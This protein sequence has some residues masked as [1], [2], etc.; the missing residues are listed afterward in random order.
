MALVGPIPAVRCLP[1]DGRRFLP[2]YRRTSA[3]RLG[4]KCTAEPLA[5][6]VE[7]EA[8]GRVK[9]VM[10]FSISDFAVANQVSVGLH[11]RVSASTNCLVIF[12]DCT[13]L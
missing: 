1:S 9:S 6:D 13:Q 5:R 3:C 4:V 7:A 10:K 8:E 11:G 12:F 2:L